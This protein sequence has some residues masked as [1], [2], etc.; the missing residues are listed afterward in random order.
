MIRTPVTELFGI[1]YPIVAGGLQW[2]ATPEYVGAAARAGIIGFVTS[3]SFPDTASLR[4][5]IRR[6][7]DLADGNPFGMN[8]SM[9]PKLVEGD[10]TEE[11]FSL[12]AQEGVRF[13]ETSGR[14]PAPYLAGLKAAGI[15]V[16]HKVPTLRHALRAEAEGV[17]AIALIG[18]E[19]GGHPGME[20]IGS[21]VQGALAGQKL[22]VPFLIGGGIGSGAQIAAALALGASGVVIGTRFLVAD[23]IWAARP[24]KERLV[25]AQH[26]DTALVMQS[27]RNTMRVLNNHLVP[28]VLAIEHEAPGD[29]ERL[30]PLVSGKRGRAAYESGDAEDAMLSLGQAVGFCDRIEPL[31]DIVKRLASEA[32][33]ATRRLSGMVSDGTGSRK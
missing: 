23:E 30:M 7:R 4:D 6:T 25:A 15:K 10:R 8:V 18:A 28:E 22:R 13:V 31:A 16:L 20:M 9:L 21:M 29:I 19:A 32:E 26:T 33:A 17:D 5:A 14:N 2:L 3:A 12:I 24:Y 11:V 1:H 27:V